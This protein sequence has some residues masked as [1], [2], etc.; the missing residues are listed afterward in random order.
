MNKLGQALAQLRVLVMRTEQ[1]AIQEAIHG[2]R[3]GLD[4]Q[5]RQVLG[6]NEVAPLGGL[7]R[8]L[9][10]IVGPLVLLRIEIGV[11]GQGG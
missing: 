7:I 3:Q 2:R 4:R 10:Y 9:P 8:A 6:L 5:F 1:A 11:P